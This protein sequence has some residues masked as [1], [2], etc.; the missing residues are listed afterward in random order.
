MGDRMRG[1]AVQRI[2]QQVE[3]DRDRAAFERQGSGAGARHERLGIGGSPRGTAGF[4]E[5][6]IL[7]RAADRRGGAVRPRHTV[8]LCQRLMADPEHDAAPGV[9]QGQNDTVR[10]EPRF[11]AEQTLR[12]G[13]REWRVRV[14][15]GEVAV[16]AQR[17]GKLVCHASRLNGVGALHRAQLDQRAGAAGGRSTGMPHAGRS[18]RRRGL[19]AERGRVGRGKPSMVREAVLQRSLGHRRHLA[20]EQRF[21]CCRESEP[22]RERTWPGAERMPQAPLQCA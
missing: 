4:G 8:C 1:V 11:E 3:R 13:R 19:L 14:A 18:Q 9:D 15:Q 12:I 16:A 2:V 21:A 22:A 17:G 7:D 6:C 10:I 5:P 20:R